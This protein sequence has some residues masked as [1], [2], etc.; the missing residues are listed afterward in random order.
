[1]TLPI[2]LVPGLACTPEVWAGQLTALWSRGPV[3]V[4]NHTVGTS[5]GDIARHILEA[6][7]PRF[8]LAGISMGGYIAF[9]IWRQAPERV[10]GLGLVDTSAR[11]DSA[12]ATE[13]R[14]AAMGLARDGK[15]AQ[16]VAAGFPLIVHPDHVEVPALKA[17]HTRMSLGVGAETYLRQQEAIIARADSRADLPNIQVP[18]VV[19]VGDRDALTPPELSE[20]MARGLPDAQLAV[21]GRAGHMALAEQPEAVN[22]VLLS[23]LDRLGG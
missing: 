3:T 10:R 8:A 19:I 14:R 18:S 9:E 20:E 22:A 13:R 17:L 5:I 11:A 7:P 4:A 2:L 15:Y 1:M 6:A 23:W 12:E 21:I 16:V